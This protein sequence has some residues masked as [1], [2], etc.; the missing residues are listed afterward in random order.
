MH[1]IL[2]GKEGTDFGG[3][4]PV[5]QKFMSVK[6]F[7]QKSVEHVNHMLDFLKARA[8]GKVPTGAQFIRDL[9]AQDPD[10]KQDSKLSLCTMTRLVHTIQK[11]NRLDDEDDDEVIDCMGT[12]AKEEAKEGQAE[13]L[14]NQAQQNH[15][16]ELQMTLGA[17]GN[18]TDQKSSAI[19]KDSI[20]TYVQAV[21]KPSTP[22]SKAQLDF[23]AFL[24]DEHQAQSSHEPIASAK[25]GS[26]D[27][28]VE[29]V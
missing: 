24:G 13:N 3:V 5:I 16:S 6:G 21:V 27:F 22:K 19:R 14:A 26:H 10:Y 15:K 28:S 29:A 18:D 8:Q 4:Y 12:Q 9:V 20:T 7:D 23:Q 2:F 1:E 17:L 25:G 11:L